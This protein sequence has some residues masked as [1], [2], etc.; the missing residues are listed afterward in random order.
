MIRII[1]IVGIAISCLFVLSSSAQPQPT[2]GRSFYT[3][4]PDDP[5]ALSVE[6]FGAVG[7][8]VADDAEA[9]Q[10]A[11][12][13]VNE[14][15][16][17]GVVLVP[18]GRY[19][20]GATLYI[21]KGIRLIGY[22]SERPA[23]VLGPETPGFQEGDGRY[24]VHFVSDRPR[25]GRPI[26]DA[27]PGTFYS[28]I[29]NIDIEIGD[30]NPAAI[31]VRSHFAQHSFLA[32]M[33][34]RIGSG[35]AGVEKVGNEIDDCR[36]FGGDYGIITTKP[37]PSWPF[38][39]ID[40]QFDGQ[41]VAAI[42]TEEGGLSLVRNQFRNVPTAIL[43]NPDR[44]E[45][46]VMVDSRLENI[47]GPALVISDE[48]NA[49][50]Q[51][52]LVNVVA[53]DTPI[54][55]MFRRSGRAVEGPA[56]IYAVE[57]FTHGLQIDDLDDSPQVRTTHRL[58]QLDR[59]PD[60]PP[61]DIATLPPQRTWV[62]VRELGAVGDGVTD[63]TQALRSAVAKHRALFFP[64]GRYRVTDTILLDSATVLIGLSPITTQI[65]L[66]DRTPAYAGAGSPKPLLE[67]PRG[68]SNVLT[69]I[70][71]DTG[72]INPRAVAAKWSA[73][74]HSMMNDVRFIGGHG[75]YKVDGSNVP[76]YN[77]SRTADGNPDRRWDTQYWSLWVT[78][79]GGGTFKDIWTPSPY[80]MA[81]LY[82]SDTDTEGRVY[83]MSLEHHVRYEA[84]IDRASNWKFFA[85]QFEEESAEGSY[86]LPIRIR[87]SR[88][89]FFANT[90]LYRVI[91]M[92]TPYPAGIVVERSSDLDFRGIHVY[93]PTKFSFDNTLIDRTSS[94]E[95]RSREI[96]R[97]TVSGDASAAEPPDSRV[98]R[99]AG[100]FEFIDGTA[101]DPDGDVWFVD[102]RR[103]H[104]YRWDHEAESL[105]LV[106]DAPVNPTALAFDESGNAVLVTNAGWRR[107]VVLTFHPDSSWT[108]L[109]EL[110]L[111]EGPLPDGRTYLWPG[112]LWRDSHDFD[113]VTSVEH[114]RYY[115]SPDGSLV[116]P[117]QDDLFRAY[118]LRKARPGHPF[119]IADEFGQKT[120]RFSVDERGRL[121]DSEVVVEEG[122]LD[123]AFGSDGRLYVAAGQIFV[124]EPDGRLVDTIRIPERPATL[125][126]AGPERDVLYV[127]ARS[128]LYRVRLR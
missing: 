62:N 116:I 56:R 94:R 25:E 9:I 115:E 23:L 35:R 123:V 15:S 39:M 79:G 118:S 112:H 36:F 40:T 71:L 70:G 54:L 12:D 67:A 18:A 45:E 117:H 88:D 95:I 59:V 13:S 46:L 63:D 90:Y 3:L 8:G 61:T 57:N 58:T 98:E 16:R 28:A 2:N 126:F 33:D 44:A 14:Q 53:V 34:F 125:V 124:Y 10:A 5:S 76:V 47:S 30:G 83:A 26:R 60:L 107:G 122:E 86:A 84:L 108:D 64:A 32:H 21:W 42:R 101:V 81:G 24:M 104:I 43:V 97:L 22:G 49:R 52:N 69:G 109:D 31:G 106:R 55:A 50:P 65:M 4:R 103:H 100:G 17:F 91:R 114:D 99:V 77:E 92:K 113:R 7:D 87:D 119:V 51:F 27:N 66:H 68:G 1:G 93:G 38:L 111:H 74:A 6:M 80:A 75:T 37:S 121:G 11:I 82:V 78:D 85:F 73:G 96:A 105:T 72:G 120:V 127:T 19:R 48:Y 110:P 128:G 89:L 20:I 102:G 41:R 29:S